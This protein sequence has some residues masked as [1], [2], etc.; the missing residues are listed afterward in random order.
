MC[1]TLIIIKKIIQIGGRSATRKLFKKFYPSITLFSFIL[2][3]IVLMGYSGFV[4]VRSQ[5]KMNAH[6]ILK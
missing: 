6:H 2:N 4:F 1:E 5:M 3:D